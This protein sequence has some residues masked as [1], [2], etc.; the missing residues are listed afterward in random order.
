MHIYFSGIGGAGIGPLALIAKEAGYLVS[1]SDKQNSQYIEYLKKHDITDIHIGQT[2]ESIDKVHNRQ[3]ID[4]FVYS[5]ALPKENPEHPELKYV[6]TNGIKHSKRD[7]FLKQIL[8]EKNLKLI[9]I[10]GTHGKSTTTAMVIWLLTQL[11]IPA[12]YSVGAKTSYAAMGKFDPKSEYFVYECDE[13]DRNFLAFNPYISLIT[14]VAWD[15]HEVFHTFDNYKEA[16]RQFMSQ[17][18]HNV[19]WQHEVDLMKLEVN[20]AYTILDYED[21]HL[22]SILLDG[23]YN[24]RNAWQALCAVQGL[25]NTP[26]NELVEITNNFPGIS[27]RMEQIAPNLFSDYAHTPEKIVAGLNTALEIAKPKNQKVVIIYEPLTNR[28]MH[29]TKDKHA[30][31]FEGAYCIYW[32][33]SYLAREDPALP[34][35]TPAEL[36]KSLH[37][38]LQEVAKPME[39][40]DD[41]KTAV[42]KHLDNNDM[43][44]AMSGGGGHSLDE[45]LRENFN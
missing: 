39:L 40:N 22:P 31:I 1:G 5:S 27:R 33:P 16:F 10:A 24:R 42:Q 44:V 17:S 14:G 15:H 8:S 37:P 41:L 45:W 7:E 38:K 2:T 4:W 6:E 3:P 11:G 18:Q 30:D 25:T 26:L 23:Q 9:A 34:I 29:Y 19:V 36:I 43:V 32:V 28:R 20:D 35:L 12:S 13:F 21:A